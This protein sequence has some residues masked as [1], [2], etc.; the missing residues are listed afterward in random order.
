MNILQKSKEEKFLLGTFKGG[1]HPYYGKEYSR[2]CAIE[3][4][5]AP[6]TVYI[7]LLQHAGKPCEAAVSVGDEVLRG[8]LIGRPSGNGAPVFSS[9]CGTVVAIETRKT[10][11]GKCPHVIINNNGKED[12]IKLPPLEDPT[13][14][15]IDERI[16]E[17]GIVGMG[18]A[19][20]PT[21]SKLKPGGGI[22][23]LIINGAECEP[24]IT[25]DYRIMLEY[26][27]KFIEGV[28]LMMKSAGAGQAIIGIEDNKAEAITKLLSYVEERDYGDIKI[29]AVKTKYPQGSDKQLI[30]AVTGLKIPK[31]VRSSSYGI[32]VNNV[33]TALDVY[34]AVKE[35]QPCYA[36]IMTV[37]GGGIN[38]PKNL[39]VSNGTLYK[40][41]IDF[42][43]GIKQDNPPL[44]IVNGGP[45]MGKAAMDEEYS[46]TKTTSSLLFLTDSQCF[47]GKPTACI[48][49]AK[50]A[51]A[52]PMRLMPMY[53]EACITA[54]DH[55][56]AERYGAN[57]CLEC[58]CCA[59]VCPAHRQLVQSIRKAKSELKARE[60]KNG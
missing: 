40:D 58:G 55:E 2:N 4:M 35:G 27:E 44:K 26:T 18:G 29:V 16:S 1:I 13:P 36:R 7:P 11:A 39:W 41:V 9:V 50:C 30:Y 14:E 23:R 17:S 5:P 37:T 48:N 60:K 32:A 3:P 38:Q 51:K 57:Y 53:I 10:S 45:M 31:G 28:R 34:L 20:F 25:C 12:F 52:C 54:G 6:Q 56:G 49:C 24:Y 15:E 33:H 43:G 19:G 59:Y 42:C 46:C 47:T 21:A 22:E 8:Q